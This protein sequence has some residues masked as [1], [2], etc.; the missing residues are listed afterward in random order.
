MY[1]SNSDSRASKIFIYLYNLKLRGE[2]SSSGQ[3]VDECKRGVVAEGAQ[4]CWTNVVSS[5]SG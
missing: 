5:S 1:S 2:G 4:E 3:I